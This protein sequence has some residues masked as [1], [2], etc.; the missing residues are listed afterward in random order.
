MNLD[1]IDNRRQ[2]KPNEKEQEK[3]FKNYENPKTHKI[4]ENGMIQMGKTLDIDIYTDTFITFFFFCCEMK[5]LD[6][7][8]LEQYKKGLKCFHANKLSD[9]KYYIQIVKGELMDITSQTFKKFY[10]FLFNL[11]AIKKPQIIPTEVV[12]VYFNS[13]F[14]EQFSFI[15]DFIHYI[16]DVAKLQGLNKDQW[17]TFIDLLVNLG[18]NFPQNYN[19]DEY[20]PLL[21][22]DFYKWFIENKNK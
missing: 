2:Y 17:I 14:A 21:F 7:V 4:D 19:T 1:F 10:E 9:I 15:K 22:D 13:F 16:K 5:N 20:Y 12:E 11:N 6:E 18:S 3:D 8:T